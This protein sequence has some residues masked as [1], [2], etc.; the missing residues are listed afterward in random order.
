MFEPTFHPSIHD[1]DTACGNIYAVAGRA[2]F[3]RLQAALGGQEIRPPTN[4]KSLT[5]AH[6]LVQAIGQDDAERLVDLAG[7]EQFYVP[8]GM[9]QVSKTDEIARELQA[10]AKTQDIARRLGISTRHVRRLKHR[11]SDLAT[12]HCNSS[13]SQQTQNAPNA[14]F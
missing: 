4:K 11:I 7:G 5:P 2:Y 8:F 6:P 9:R 12:L 1:Q 14:S 3:E 10:G 13:Q